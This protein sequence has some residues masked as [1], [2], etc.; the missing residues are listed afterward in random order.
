M[1]RCATAADGTRLLRMVTVALL[2]ARGRSLADRRVCRGKR[3]SRRTETTAVDSAPLRRSRDAVGVDRC[4]RHGRGD[5]VLLLL[6][7]MRVRHVVLLLPFHPPVLKPDLDLA[8][9]EVQHV[10]DFNATSSRQVAIEVELFLELQSLVP[11]VRCPRPLRVDAVSVVR[12]IHKT[13]HKRMQA[14]LRIGSAGNDFTRI[15][16]KIQQIQVTV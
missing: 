11:R 2:Y 8:L 16:I 3:R 10:G 12:C 7:M 5:G 1:R 4:R 13:T 9:A 15:D 6:L 14:K